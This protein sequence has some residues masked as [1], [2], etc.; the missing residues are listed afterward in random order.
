MSNFKKILEQ[1]CEETLGEGINS[2][3]ASLLK[4][5]CK[6]RSAAAGRVGIVTSATNT[7]V[8]I[9]RKNKNAVTSFEEGDEV[10]IEK[11]DDEYVIVNKG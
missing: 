11:H 1:L 9:K 8:T 5:G 3:I 6:V 4:K 7:N 2:R 10:T